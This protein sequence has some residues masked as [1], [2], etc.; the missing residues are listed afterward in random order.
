V[1]FRLRY[2][3][4]RDFPRRLEY[5]G[6]TVALEIIRQS[7]GSDKL[8]RFQAKKIVPPE[9]CLIAESRFGRYSFDT[10]IFNE[11]F[12]LDEASPAGKIMARLEREG[13]AASRPERGRA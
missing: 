9:I 2:V 13:F 7:R 1:P 8:W 6:A 11:G 10:I 5:R 12:V 3:L 4:R